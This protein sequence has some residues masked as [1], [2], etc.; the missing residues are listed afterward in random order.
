MDE[1]SERR[2]FGYPRGTYIEVVFICFALNN[3][4]VTS[5]VLL[6]L[7]VS[8]FVVVLNRTKARVGNGDG[9]QRR[10][11]RFPQWRNQASSCN[12]Q[13]SVLVVTRLEKRLSEVPLRR[14]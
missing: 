6:L 8:G 2:Y 7:V 11:I 5:M 13:R 14:F 1:D 10:I 4:G 12:V 9:G 3:D